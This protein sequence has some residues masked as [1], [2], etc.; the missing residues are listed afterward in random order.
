MN[1]GSFLHFYKVKRLDV[2]YAGKLA[3]AK[4]RLTSKKGGA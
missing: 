4:A 1:I 2:K 3:A